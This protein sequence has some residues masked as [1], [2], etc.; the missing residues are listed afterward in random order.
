MPPKRKSS[1][2][3]YGK[4]TPYLDPSSPMTI[5]GFPVCPLAVTPSRRNLFT[6]HILAEAIQPGIKIPNLSEYKGIG[7]PQTT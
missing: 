6:P 3:R 5:G 1:K 7:D 4:G 2:R